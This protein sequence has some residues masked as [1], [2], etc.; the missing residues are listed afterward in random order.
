MVLTR[1]QPHSRS[2][3]ACFHSWR[4]RNLRDCTTKGTH[5]LTHTHPAQVG[6]TTRTHTTHTYHMHIH[7]SCIYTPAPRVLQTTH[8]YTTHVYIQCVYTL[9]PH[10]CDTPHTY[11]HHTRTH[12]TCMHTLCIY[13]H[14]P[15]ALHTTHIYASYVDTHAKC[16]TLHATP[17][18]CGAHI[19][20]PY[21][22][23]L[24]ITCTCMPQMR[25]PGIYTPRDLCT[26][27]ASTW[28]GRWEPGALLSWPWNSVTNLGAGPSGEASAGQVRRC[29]PHLCH[30]SRAL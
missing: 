26:H 16:A 23:R 22:P 10:G 2:G 1:L 28:A 6:H 19:H 25:T 17:C 12:H 21:P 27:S 30:L 8:I 20:T 7:A 15:R 24:Y 14:A 3:S 11:T 5:G 9:T 29:C 18:T 4:G 13:T